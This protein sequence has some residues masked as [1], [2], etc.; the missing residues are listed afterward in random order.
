VVVVTTVGI[1]FWEETFGFAFGSVLLGGGWNDTVAIVV[2]LA[3]QAVVSG[4]LA[5]R[6]VLV[7]VVVVGHHPDHHTE[8]RS[9][10]E[11]DADLDADVNG[12]QTHLLGMT[13]RGHEFLL[14][15]TNV[16]L[17]IFQHTGISPSTPDIFGL[18]ASRI[19]CTSFHSTFFQV[20]LSIS[21][22]AILYDTCK[23]TFFFF[24]LTSKSKRA[25]FLGWK[26][27]KKAMSRLEIPIRERVFR[28]AVA[29]YKNQ[30]RKEWSAM[31]HDEPRKASH[32]MRR[33][34]MELSNVLTTA[35][36]LLVLRFSA[37]LFANPRVILPICQQWERMALHTI[38][39]E[40][41]AGEGRVWTLLLHLMLCEPSLEI[42]LEPMFQDYQTMVFP[43]G[44]GNCVLMELMYKHGMFKDSPLDIEHEESRVTSPAFLRFD[45][46]FLPTVSGRMALNFIGARKCFDCVGYQENSNVA[47]LLSR[48]KE[49]LEPV[50][51]TLFEHFRP[52]IV[53][54]MLVA[55]CWACCS[56]GPAYRESMSVCLAHLLVF[57]QRLPLQF[58]LLA[59]S[60]PGPTIDK[61]EERLMRLI[62]KRT[63]ILRT[64]IEF[65][66][67][68]C[69]TMG[70]SLL[71][72]DALYQAR[73]KTLEETSEK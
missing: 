50:Y 54:C 52:C 35:D 58:E 60:P 61:H 6:V 67:H 48:L 11:K 13:P 15:G 32:W 25:Y 1:G 21:L 70:Y 71:A 14:R 62:L 68:E 24:D 26:A 3:D 5:I 10:E 12:R 59:R 47:Y 16:R 73:W 18:A 56:R 42:G 64:T 33:E 28:E 20:S 23:V 46:R 19:F 31:L 41:L 17:R 53:A 39:P 49:H 30:L 27:S 43:M 9:Y 36:D 4:R 69:K 72:L 51:T 40:A 63:R 57:L 55:I 2:E 22:K 65:F 66:Q 45:V 38:A 7:R 37:G 44:M 29:L 34:C 8:N